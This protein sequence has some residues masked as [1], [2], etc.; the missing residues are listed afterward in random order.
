MYLGIKKVVF[1]IISVTC[2]WV[3]HI[4][5]RK[6]NQMIFSW[7]K[8]CG[9][10]VRWGDRQR[11]SALGRCGV[12][13]EGPFAL[14]LHLPAAGRARRAAMVS[15]LRR[16]AV[17]DA[18]NIHRGRPKVWRRGEGDLARASRASEDTSA[19]ASFYHLPVFIPMV[20]V[21]GC[22]SGPPTAADRA[23]ALSRRPRSRARRP[24][25]RKGGSPSRGGRR[26]R[27]CCSS[28]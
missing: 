21:P 9:P 10:P 5:A 13:S 28:R 6:I 11:N 16:G 3:L 15:V 18:A 26:C 24:C 7:G 1:S 8:G 20:R 22:R 25:R 19:P 14:A 2:T 23:P 17:R 12:R 27:G 4:P